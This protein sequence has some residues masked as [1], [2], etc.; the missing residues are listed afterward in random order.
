MNILGI[1]AFYS[2]P[3]AAVIKDNEVIAVCREEW[4]AKDSKDTFPINSVNFCLQKAGLT[5]LDIECVALFEKPFLRFE[6]EIIAYLNCFPFNF[7]S[8]LKEMPLWLEKRLSFPYFLKKLTDYDGPVV[9]VNNDLAHAAAGFFM[10]GFSECSAIV[11]GSEGEWS[12]LSRFKCSAQ[13][14]S[15]Y[16]SIDY[17]H[18]PAHF[19]NAFA[20]FLGLNKSHIHSCLAGLALKSTL[21]ADERI[22][23]IIDIKKDGSFRL[24][25]SF[26]DFKNPGRPY[27]SAFVKLFGPAMAAP[28]HRPDQ[29]PG[30]TPG[31]TPGHAL[32]HTPEHC[33]IALAVQNSV[34]KIILASI[35]DLLQKSDSPALDTGDNPAGNR[36]KNLCLCSSLFENPLLNTYILQNAPC[37]NIFIN[38]A[39]SFLSP[40]L[41]A[42][43]FAH[44]YI[45]SE[46]EEHEEH[47]EHK[48]H[49]E[50]KFHTLLK[51]F[52]PQTGPGLTNIK[53]KRL[54]ASRGSQFSDLGDL[55]QLQI[56]SK[57]SSLIAED[58]LTGLYQQERTCYKDP[59]YDRLVL[60]AF[61]KE[62]LTKIDACCS[63]NIDS[64][65]IPGVIGF[66]DRLEEYFD[67]PAPKI[68]PLDDAGVYVSSM[69]D[70][71]FHIG[72]RKFRIYSLSR[73]NTAFTAGI[74]KI[75]EKEYNLPFCF[76]L[77]LII[78]STGSEDPGFYASNFADS[79]L[80]NLLLE[81][82]LLQKNV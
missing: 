32:E 45:Y 49:K 27:T 75:L 61:S 60:A 53:I 59:F 66:I 40:A 37:E 18:S 58:Q 79:G 76:F 25:N 54:L 71:R 52:N 50:Q 38:P 47:K 81:K 9:Y 15:L 12:G 35:N 28:K 30:H 2:G 19:I 41:G 72:D 26:F 43:V 57:I 65:F 55:S 68:H 67:L 22:N 20:H 51:P 44:D 31:H 77:P 13:G 78:N 1:S 42:A 29:I 62:G 48:E 11:C 39:D 64:N 24:N 14:I 73:E 4:L 17:P 16:D 8:F 36:A 82:C 80:D 74:L 34:Q 6:K 70:P 10:S 33:S 46:H 56:M 21:P 69:P 3:S 7:G 5:I 23:E 63:Q